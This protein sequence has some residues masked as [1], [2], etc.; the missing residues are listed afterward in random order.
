MILESYNPYPK[1]AICFEDARQVSG[2]SKVEV[3][4]R[5]FSY[6]LVHWLVYSLDFKR[7]CAG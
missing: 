3:F 6:I 4:L 2:V 5:W 7:G 1:E